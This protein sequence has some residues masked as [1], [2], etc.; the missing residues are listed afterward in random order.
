MRF[1]PKQAILRAGAGP[2]RVS[3]WNSL[4]SESFKSEE[5][6]DFKRATITLLAVVKL[7]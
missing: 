6:C 7:D 3:G 2:G 5:K 1:I 4:V